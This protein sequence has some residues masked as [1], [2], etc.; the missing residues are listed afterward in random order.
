MQKDGLRGE[1][2]SDLGGCGAGKVRR[3]RRTYVA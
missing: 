1:E 2:V 3:W